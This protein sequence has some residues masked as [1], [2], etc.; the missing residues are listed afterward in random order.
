MAASDRYSWDD[1]SDSI[2]VYRGDCYINT[3]THRM[4]WNFIDPE[5][6]TNTKVVDPWNWYKNYRIKETKIKLSGDVMLD[7]ANDE[8]PT[9]AGVTT[10]AT[11]KKVLDLFTYKTVDYNVDIETDNILALTTY[12]LI[13]PDGKKFSKY[14][15]AN[16]S[17]G[18][19][20][21]NRP[22]VNGIPIGHW[23]TFKI[24]SNVNL[25]MRDI[26]FSRPEEEAVHGD[27]RKFHPFQKANSSIKLPESSILNRGISRTLSEKYYFEIPDVPFIKDTFTTRIHYS[28]T[29][30]DTAF[31]NGNR[32]FRSE[33][34]QDYTLEY[35]QLVKLI[36]WFGTLIAVMEHGILMI[37]VNERAM[38]KNQSG[39]DV[40]INTA[41]VLPKN[42]KVVSNTYG[43][44]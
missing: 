3:Y 39:E 32:V 1:V 35:G 42:P 30:V 5:L 43:S 25:A 2:D 33:N 15:E 6:P 20:Y 44:V 24:C 19:K 22:D 9:G 12:K 7:D 4:N 14:A 26:D 21:L 34:Y 8:F 37:P 29:L 10:E 11:Y 27:K 23:A 18:T 41:N 17:F 31:K 36:E 16:G 13:L 40:Y 28:D 38:M